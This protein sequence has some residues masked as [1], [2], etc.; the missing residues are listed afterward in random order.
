MER[1]R[2][3]LKRGKRPAWRSAKYL[4]ALDVLRE[5]KLVILERSQGACEAAF[6][7]HCTGV[8]SHAHHRLTRARGGGHDPENL[9]WTC[10]ICHADLHANPAKADAAGLLAS[11]RAS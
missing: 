7:E 5:S 2:K 9:V 1:Q 4:A 8:G 10:S 11:R 3:Y 6:S